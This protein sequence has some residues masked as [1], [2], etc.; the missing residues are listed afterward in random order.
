MDFNLDFNSLQQ[1]SEDAKKQKA[2]MRAA[3][4]G[5]DSVVNSGNES[6]SNLQQILTGQKYSSG[7]KSTIGESFNAASES[8]DDPWE[9][10][11]QLYGMQRETSEA[12]NLK[13]NQDVLDRKKDPNSRESMALRQLAPRWGIKVDP[14]ASAFEIEQMIDPKNMMQTEA[15]ASVDFKNDL[16]KLDYQSALAKNLDTHKT[17]ED[18]RK[19]A[20]ARK[21]NPEKFIWD[22][23]KPEN[24]KQIEDLAGTNAKTYSVRSFLSTGLDKLKDPNLSSDEKIKTGQEMLK[25]INSPLGSDAVGAEEVK[26]LGSFLENKFLNLSQPG[27]MFGRDF[28]TFVKQVENNVDRLGNAISM[29]QGTIDVLRKNQPLTAN[30]K[31]VSDNEKTAQDV[32]MLQE[33]AAS[34][35]PQ[36]RDEKMMA[37]SKLKLSGQIT[38][39]QYKSRR[40]Q[41]LGGP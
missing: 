20:E 10:Q 39:E 33:A 6:Q 4:L 23:L 9:K 31:P 12:K 5:F 11:K 36:N 22:E 7:P 21:M 37:L 26:R 3:G 18:L 27:S 24:R 15:K 29:N 16:K 32:R 34:K 2:L 41:I 30:I 13:D 1:Q 40:K 35:A 8:I 19:T 25:F 14:S 17:N 28:D 38:D